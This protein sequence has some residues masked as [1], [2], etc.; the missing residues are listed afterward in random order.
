LGSFREVLYRLCRNEQRWLGYHL[1]AIKSITWLESDDSDDW[2]R[3]FDFDPDPGGDA[4][5]PD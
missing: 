1:W 3:D 5:A 2:L 4:E